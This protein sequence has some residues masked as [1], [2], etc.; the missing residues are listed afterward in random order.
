MGKGL[1]KAKQTAVLALLLFQYGFP[2]TARGQ[3][4][5][6]E[7]RQPLELVFADSI[8]P[9]DR[10]E[11][12]LTTGAW[13]FQQHASHHASLTEKIEWGVSDALQ[14]STT[15]QLVNNS[16]LTGPTKT[17]IGDLEI[18]ARYT[19]PTLGSEFTHLALAFDAGFPTGSSQRGLG[20]GAYT[21]SPSMLLSRELSR[22]KYQ[23]FSTTGVEIVVK[24]RRVAALQD[25]T[26]TSAFSNGGLSIHAGSGWVVGEIS[27]SSNRWSGGNETQLAI[28]PSYVWRLAKRS[29]L[30]LAVPIGIT[31][32]TDRVGAVIK[33]TF[34]FG[35]K[36]D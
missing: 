32:S 34:E 2:A 9:Q 33:F 3:Q 25:P 24:H 17:G 6:L 29:E 1:R 20:E 5:S 28:T 8:V 14:I 21:V 16:N 13:Y 26:R 4:K 36:P 12:M 11:T 10:H 31:S 27:F 23:V 15:I 18:G 35:G 22:G 19:W 30:L 7:Q